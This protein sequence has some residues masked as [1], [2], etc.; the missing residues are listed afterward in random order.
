MTSSLEATRTRAKRFV[1]EPDRVAP[2]VRWMDR[3]YSVLEALARF[4]FLTTTQLVELVFGAMPSA[5]L[6]FGRA[7][8]GLV[9]LTLTGV[10]RR[11]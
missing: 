1:P 11:D 10:L 8:V 7:L 4:R 6:E 2:I 3:D 9:V 5:C